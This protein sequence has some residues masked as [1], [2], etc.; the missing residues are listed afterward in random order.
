MSSD[1]DKRGR[2]GRYGLVATLAALGL[3]LA[4]PG[5]ALAAPDQLKGGSVQIQL[6][7]GRGLKLSPRGLSLPIMGGAI[8]PIDGSGTVEVRG[9]FRAKRGKGKAK[10]KVRE[11][12]FGANGGGGSIA[13]KVGKRKVGRFGLLSG[14]TVTRDGWGAQIA[15]VTAKLGSKGAK[16]LDAAFSPRK[17]KA[18]AARVKGGQTLG[19]VSVT[20]DPRTVEVLPGG[21]LVFSADNGFVNKLMAHCVF[22]LLPGGVEAIPPATQSLTLTDFTFPV[23]GGS[24]SPDFSA[25]RVTSAGGQT[26]AKNFDLGI[27]FSCDEGPAAGTKVV[28]TEFEAQFDIQALASATVLPEGPVGIASLGTFDL[29]AATTKS[30]DLNTKQIR[31]TDAPVH[32]DG[33]TAFILNQVFPNESTD[34]SNDF[35]GGDLVGTLSLSVKTH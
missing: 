21:E 31:I 20:T 7:N 6:Q 1:R 32:L 17:G 15:G 23:T 28:Q 4:A 29:G 30:A 24:I 27:P 10:V 25:G 5:A 33:F 11:L 8:D 35:G 14:G 9:A 34:A 18:A 22:G 13:V 19:T 2:A 3:W 16:A 26:I 12:T